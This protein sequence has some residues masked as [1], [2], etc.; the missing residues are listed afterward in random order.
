[1]FFIAFRSFTRLSRQAP[2]LRMEPLLLQ[3]RL[4]LV[5]CGELF[6]SLSDQL[7]DGQDGERRGCAGEGLLENSEV[8]RLLLNPLIGDRVK[9]AVP[10]PAPP[11]WKRCELGSQEMWIAPVLDIDR[12]HLLVR[13]DDPQVIFVV[14]RPQ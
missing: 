4:R 7:A 1:M 14:S 9:G 12:P 11:I 5:H 8:I 3:S 2:V 10:G 13:K 6:V